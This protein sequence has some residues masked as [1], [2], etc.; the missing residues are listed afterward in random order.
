VRTLGLYGF[1]AAAHIVCQVAAHDGRD[2]L[3]FTR[4]G[5]AEGQAFALA[6]GARWAGGSDATPPEPLDAAILFAPA[7]ELVP[8]ALRAVAPGG[9][10]VCAG[11]H[12]T[13]IPRFPYRLLWEERTLTSVANLTRQDGLDFLDLAPRVPVVTRVTTYPLEDANRALDDLR[14]GRVHGAAVLVP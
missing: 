6:T 1:G 8:L 7:G 5:D 2:V 10:V 9:I 12:M 4:P 14:E 11:I 3:A 13:D